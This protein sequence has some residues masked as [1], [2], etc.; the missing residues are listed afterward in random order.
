VGPPRRKIYVLGDV[1]VRVDVART[2]LAQQGCLWGGPR[3]VIKDDFGGKLPSGRPYRPDVHPCP[4][5]PRGRVFTV[6]RRGKKRVRADMVRPR[7][8]TSLPPPPPPP[9]S[10]PPRL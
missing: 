8:R 7:G 9:P 6:H 3:D 1:D 4:R 10:P 5:L 2:E